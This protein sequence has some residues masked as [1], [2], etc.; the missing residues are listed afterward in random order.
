MRVNYVDA[1]EDTNHPHAE[2]A[3]PTRYQAVKIR[4]IQGAT[5]TTLATADTDRE[6]YLSARVTIPAS[7]ATGDAFIRVDHVGTDA[8]LAIE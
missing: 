3:V 2:S 6:G 7:A 8:F 4:L 5:Q 1:C